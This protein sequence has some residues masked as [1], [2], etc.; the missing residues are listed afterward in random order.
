MVESADCSEYWSVQHWGRTGTAGQVKVAGGL[1]LQDAVAAFE[2][3][4]KEKSGLSFGDRTSAAVPGKYKAT[5][6]EYG[7]QVFAKWQYYVDDFVDGKA[8][9]W[10]P[11]QVGVVSW[12][13]PSLP[14]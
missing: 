3:K 4:F 5:R 1:S 13:C 7:E 6:R 9:G 12:C 2:V 10:Y 14:L 11:Y 8:D